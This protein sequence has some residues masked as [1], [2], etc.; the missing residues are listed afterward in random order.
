LLFPEKYKQGSIVF[1]QTF[2]LSILFFILVTPLYVYIN[3]VKPEVLI[4]AFLFH[5]LINIFIASL[6]SEILS[7]YRYILLSLYGS[8]I[9]FFFTS[10]LS[11]IFFMNF[12][13]S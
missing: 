6:L 7:S 2:I 9:G 3:L 8:F 13:S 5:V 11:V 4:L 12:S 10:V 1:G